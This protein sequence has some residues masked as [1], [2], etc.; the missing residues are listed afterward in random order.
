[1]IC[2]VTCGSRE[3][4]TQIISEVKV[5]KIAIEDDI[6]MRNNALGTRAR[7]HIFIHTEY[8][9]SYYRGAV[10]ELRRNMH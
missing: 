2:S 6:Q 7:I 9:A 3:L 8:G 4:K 10:S 1:M 5:E